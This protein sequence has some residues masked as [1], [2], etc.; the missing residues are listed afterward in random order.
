LSHR[1]RTTPRPFGPPAASASRPIAAAVAALLG[2][3]TALVGIPLSATAAPVIV[4]TQ[5]FA[6]APTTGW[7]S[8][9]Q[10]WAAAGGKYTADA[11]GFT[12]LPALNYSLA[13]LALSTAGYSDV[14]V[15]FDY[16][17]T[18]LAGESLLVNYANNSG[19]YSTVLS[20]STDTA[21]T[22]TG[23][24]ALTD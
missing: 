7:T 12:N 10:P 20:Q 1:S 11:S 14:E 23:W 22:S 24:V 21:E 3:V 4:Y 8:G 18:D 19:G 9:G 13:S 17:A 6:S 5:T 16:S 15:R 2:L